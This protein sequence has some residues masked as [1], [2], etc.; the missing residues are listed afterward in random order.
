MKALYFESF[1]GPEVLQYGDIADP[2][3]KADTLLV[4]TTVIGLNFADIYRRR[5][6]YHIE[7]HQP[8]LM[9]M[10]ESESSRQLARRCRNMRLAS[11]CCLLTFRLLMLRW[12]PCQWTE[13]FEYRRD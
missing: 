10:K 6:H 5:G 2:V 11:A 9:V 7:Q 1:G 4:K 13:P 3:V 12:S 8:T